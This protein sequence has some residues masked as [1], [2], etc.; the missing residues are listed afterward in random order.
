MTDRNDQSSGADLERRLARA[1]TDV[2][3]PA[4]TWPKIAAAISAES[5]VLDERA[6]RLIKERAPP[7]DLWPAI[8]ARLTSDAAMRSGRRSAQRVWLLPGAGLAAA[9]ALGVLIGRQSSE[10]V[11][12]GD[13]GADAGTLVVAEVLPPDQR[14]L[15]ASYRRAVGEHLRTAET[16]LVLFNSAEEPDEELTRLA[17]ELAATSRLLMGSRAGEDPQVHAMLLDLELLLMQVARVV[18]DDTVEKQVVREGTAD[19]AVLAR[20]RLMIA[21]ESGRPGI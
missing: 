6:G 13:S 1:P 19:P 9:L 15:P 8:H 10:I 12:D 17:R 7:A 11:P 3:A 18:D 4:D 14:P 20:L 21:E 16:V 5:T 2:E